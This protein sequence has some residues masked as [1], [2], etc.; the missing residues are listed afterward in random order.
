M[1]IVSGWTRRL[2]PVPSL[3][4]SAAVCAL[5]THSWTIV[6]DYFLHRLPNFSLPVAVDVLAT[7]TYSR[8]PTVIK[9]RFY[10]LSYFILTRAICPCG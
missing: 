6:V 4:A 9:V 1:L 7:G 3:S 2:W 8:L 5:C 10:S